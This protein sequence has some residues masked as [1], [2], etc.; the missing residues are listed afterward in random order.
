MESET[1]GNPKHDI[2][3]DEQC[4]TIEILANETESTF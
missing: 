1:N 3:N 4:P 2:P